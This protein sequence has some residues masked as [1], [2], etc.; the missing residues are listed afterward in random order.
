MG[1]AET[2]GMF[3]TTQSRL[4]EFRTMETAETKGMFYAENIC[5]LK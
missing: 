2:E 1:T 4:G 3:F 5:M